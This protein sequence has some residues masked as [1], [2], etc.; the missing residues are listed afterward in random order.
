M[1]EEDDIDKESGF[2]IFNIYPAFIKI[3]AENYDDFAGLYSLYSSEDGKLRYNGENKT[4]QLNDL[5]YPPLYP[6]R[7]HIT[8]IK[9]FLMS[10]KYNV[11]TGTYAQVPPTNPGIKK[12]FRE[13]LEYSSKKARSEDHSNWLSTLSDLDG[14]SLETP[15]IPL[16][17]RSEQVG[18]ASD[19][20][21]RPSRMMSEQVGPSSFNLDGSFRKAS[22][23]DTP[24]PH[25]GTDETE[26]EEPWRQE[27]AAAAAEAADADIRAKRADFSP[28][29]GR[30]SRFGNSEGLYKE[31]NINNKVK[32]V[33]SQ[34][35]EEDTNQ[36]ERTL[37]IDITSLK[38]FDQ[39]IGVGGIAMIFRYFQF[40]DAVHDLCEIGRSPWGSTV[41]RPN[42]YYRLG[43]I[44][45]KDIKWML[46]NNYRDKN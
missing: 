23:F 24:D 34:L 26:A 41:N 12:I 32:F 29:R 33:S 16:K 44:Y 46:N 7:G 3:D 1:E 38:T 15:L 25:A 14:S 42:V 36:L 20:P 22:I 5:D 8:T 2:D 30:P 11:Y 37:S 31:F 35:E 6:N 13:F 9:D 17:T 10:L 21:L 43:N 45:A 39:K 40:L 4:L 18:S 19:T 28:G 27:E